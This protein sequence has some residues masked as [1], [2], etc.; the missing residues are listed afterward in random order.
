MKFIAI[1]LGTP[2][3]IPANNSDFL[4]ILPEVYDARSSYLTL[5][6]FQVLAHLGVIKATKYWS[7]ANVEYGLGYVCPLPI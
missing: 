3:T 2:F 6:L 7:T 4:D 5:V 1:K